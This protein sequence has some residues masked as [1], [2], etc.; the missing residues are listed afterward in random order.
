MKWNIAAP[1][2][3]SEN[4]IWIDDCITDGSL[5]FEKI[6]RPTET[7][8]WHSRKTT[9]TGLKGWA[10]HWKHA[11]LALSTPSD[12][13]ITLFPQLPVVSGLQMSI[14]G[15]ERPLIAWCFNLGA[16]Y[17]GIK[18][19][20]SKLALSRVSK[21]IVHS[22]AEVESYSAWLGLPPEKFVFVPLQ[23][24]Q[25]KIEEEEESEDPFILSVGSAKRDYT[26]LFKAVEPLG[27]KTIV[28]ASELAIQNLKVPKNV[29]VLHNIPHEE[30]RRYV[31][32]ARINIVP[33]DNDQTASGQ[34]TVIEAMKFGRP[35][36]ASKCI[37]TIDYV[38]SGEDGILVEPKS[39]EELTAQIE[40][41]W[42]D[43]NLRRQ[44]GQ[45]AKTTADNRYSDNAAG[46]SLRRILMEFK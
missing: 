41:L 26:T 11:K 4:S 36:I 23:R 28:I 19:K 46:E 39:V 43:S 29:S 3:R 30:C 25:F 14:R 7:Q 45:A 33:I 24:G 20:L 17:P 10:G 35:V 27:Y 15:D 32:R 16:C 42:S 21:F 9:M 2:F 34:V 37:G 6:P 40:R 22:T 13:I 18:Q 8:S 12:G 38:S 1:F 31:Q 5:V 44:L